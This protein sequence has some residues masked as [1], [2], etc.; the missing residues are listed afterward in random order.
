MPDFVFTAKVVG[1][2]TIQ[3][4]RFADSE[5]GLVSQLRKEGLVV[6]SIAPASALSKPSRTKRG[7]RVKV[8]DL[9]ILCRQLSTM[10][11]AGLPVLESLD[12]IGDQI[13]NE[14]LGNVLTQVS[15]DIEA[16]STLSQALAK[17]E[18]I[19]SVLFVAMVKAGEES[20]ALPAVLGRL[21]DY[22]EARDALTKKIMSASAYPAFIAGF[23]IVAVAGIMLF[24]IPQFEG[25]FES[26]DLELPLLTK[27][28]IGMSRFIGRNLAK[29]K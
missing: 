14:G 27:T 23:F 18:R 29:M 7:K 4:T 11:E 16:G 24:L 28:L 25:I 19:F 10:L 21:A 20:G 22:L 15:S 8:R 26:F 1:G 13:E 17:H 2:K 5:L 3:D 12:G 6:I 9:A